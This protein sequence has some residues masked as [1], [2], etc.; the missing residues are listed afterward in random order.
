MAWV[1]AKST[2][3]TRPVRLIPTECGCDRSKTTRS[4]S[5]GQF[6]ARWIARIGMNRQ[7]RPSGAICSRM[8]A[9]CFCPSKVHS[10]ALDWSS[11]GTCQVGCTSTAR[12]K[13][14]SDSSP[15][16]NARIAA[17]TGGESPGNEPADGVDGMSRLIS[18][19]GVLECRNIYGSPAS[20]LN[21]GGGT[22]RFDAA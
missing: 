21:I 3:A 4:V 1:D 13:P 14:S 22:R 6:W 9:R 5:S 8:A 10:R 16:L 19:D 17:T 18:R 12:N 15:E 7:G 2:R 20:A 11:T